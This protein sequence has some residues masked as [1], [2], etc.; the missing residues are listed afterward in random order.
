MRE[1]LK[2]VLLIHGLPVV[3]GVV[4]FGLV[5]WE[6]RIMENIIYI[7]VVVGLVVVFDWWRNI[8]R[9]R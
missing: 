9:T 6:G 2:P 3:M 4:L 5:T 7:A 8:W 1:W